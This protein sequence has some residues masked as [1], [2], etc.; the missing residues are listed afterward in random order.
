VHKIKPIE[1]KVEFLE[2]ISSNQTMA[3]VSSSQ[4]DERTKKDLAK[5]SVIIKKPEPMFKVVL[6]KKMQRPQTTSDLFKR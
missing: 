4:K 3:V 5:A 1:N 2:P 6:T